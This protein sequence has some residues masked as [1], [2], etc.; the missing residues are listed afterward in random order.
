MGSKSVR[1]FW[2][3]LP[4]TSKQPNKICIIHSHTLARSP[5]KI[6]AKSA[7]QGPSNLL[8]Q[9]STRAKMAKV[10]CFLCFFPVFWP[11]LQCTSIWPNQICII[12]SHILACLS[13]EISARSA[14]RGP[15]NRPWRGATC[16]ILGRSGPLFQL[17]DH[18]NIN[19][20]GRFQRYAFFTMPNVTT[21]S[22]V[23][24]GQPC[25]D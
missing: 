19:R 16:V 7:H 2:H 15:S 14:H 21:E 8:R 13:C 6:S 25:S 22:F 12:R 11:L 18:P 3:L 17:S 23:M 9:Q 5:R 4:C 24:I 1:S 20:L 10:V